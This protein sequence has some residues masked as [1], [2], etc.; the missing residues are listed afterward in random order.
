MLQGSLLSESKTNLIRIRDVRG[1]PSLFLCLHFFFL[2]IFCLAYVLIS[3]KHFVAN[4][5]KEY[6]LR[7]TFYEGNDYKPCYFKMQSNLI[8]L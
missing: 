3:C 5:A 8:F 2:P 1:S 4:A 6:L 7:N